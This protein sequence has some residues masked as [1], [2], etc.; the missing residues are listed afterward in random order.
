MILK[1]NMKAV[2]FNRGVTEVGTIV[3]KRKIKGITHYSV[4]LERGYLMESITE[5]TEKQF[6][7][8][9]DLSLKLNNT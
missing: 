3:K 4:M 8:L 9:V 1:K 6:Y 5:D 7:M 2:V